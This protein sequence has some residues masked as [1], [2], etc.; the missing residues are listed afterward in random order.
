MKNKKR[1][2]KLNREDSTVVIERLRSVDVLESTICSS[3]TDNKTR[4]A[5]VS[6]ILILI[7]AILFSFVRRKANT[8]SPKRSFGVNYRRIE[9]S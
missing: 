1:N 7:R 9:N 8:L 2:V 6:L 3:I 4:D 5:L